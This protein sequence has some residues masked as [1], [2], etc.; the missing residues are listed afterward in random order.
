MKLTLPQLSFD[1]KLDEF[2]FWLTPSLIEIRASNRY[3]EV[4]IS[5]C[6]LIE[7]IGSTTDKFKSFKKFSAEII[8]K[9]IK[10]HIK[11]LEVEEKVKIVED[12]ATFLFLVT[13]KSDNNSKCQF[14]I[15]LRDVARIS[16]YPRV[17]SSKGAKSLSI[18]EIPREIKSDKMARLVGELSPFPEKQFEFLSQ[19]IKFVI[20]KDFYLKSLWT[21]GNTYF[22]MKE[23]GFEKDFLQPMII[24]QVRGSVSAS[25]GHEP[26]DILRERMLEW[27]L[28][29]N[30]DFNNSDIV[31][32]D[33]A[34][35]D[36]KAD[37]SKLREDI[38]QPHLIMG[39]SLAF[40]EPKEVLVEVSTEDTV[41]TVI[42]K[43]QVAMQDEIKGKT[44]AYDFVLPF[45]VEG[46]DQKIFVQCQFYAGDSGSV[47]HKNVDQTR[48]SRDF[49]KTKRSN[50]I[51]LE[52]IDGAGYFSSLW[53][54]LKKILAMRD[55]EDFFQVRTAVIKLRG[56]LQALGFLT[57]L[58]VIHA[59][60]LNN[61]NLDKIIKYLTEDG[62]SKDEIKRVTSD[63]FFRIRNK[64]L[65]FDDS[66]IELSRR[67]LLLDFIAKKGKRFTDYE[68]MTGIILV[69]AYGKFFGLRI[70]DIIS[71]IVPVSGKFQK[72]WIQSGIIFKD[73]QFLADKGW[74]AQR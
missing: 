26:E 38:S 64:R 71:E 73:I 62:Y 25:G 6:S 7:I 33:L 65:F 48:T 2:D 11:K 39:Q 31:I 60:A 28:K 9:A 74:I 67:Y 29:P 68:K 50:P 63:Q 52:Y 23:I 70:E 45:K 54:D 61:G 51:F 19:Y 24:F 37:L 17:Q 3:N 58:E 66:V 49:V 18:T 55:T 53:G 14:P 20:D 30:V 59:W 4:Q 72:Q 34:V 46:W 56:K 57:R 41:E 69:P 42:E 13:G 15:F 22:K 1:E 36:K 8:A 40:D 10:E 5:I 43:A 16:S 27:G 35:I 32:T 44:R 21:I 12:L 47:S